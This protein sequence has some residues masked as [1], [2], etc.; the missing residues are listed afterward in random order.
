MTEQY[1]VHSRDAYLAEKKNPKALGEAI[2]KVL[3]NEKLRK[4]LAN[5]GLG[6]LDRY[7]FRNE[8][9]RKKILEVFRNVT[10]PPARN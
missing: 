3:G 7:G 9:I 4:K 10:T 1:F 5:N 2:V 6:F 8:V